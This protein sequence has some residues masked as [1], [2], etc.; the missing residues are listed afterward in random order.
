MLYKSY[1]AR[2]YLQFLGEQAKQGTLQEEHLPL[3]RWPGKRIKGWW[4]DVWACPWFRQPG[5]ML[6]PW[7]FMPCLF[8]IMWMTILLRQQTRL[9]TEVDLMLA[10]IL[11]AV[12][13]ALVCVLLVWSQGKD[14]ERMAERG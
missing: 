13:I 14:E 9:G 1:Q 5:D 11:S 2:G 10:A 4:R 7:L 6:E 8:M 12:I 3:V